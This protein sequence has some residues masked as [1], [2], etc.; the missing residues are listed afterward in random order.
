SFHNLLPQLIKRSSKEMILNLLELLETDKR[1]T[2]YL[3]ALVV[4]ADPEIRL[5]TLQILAKR[6]EDYSQKVESL[7]FDPDP[8]VRQEAIHY[9]LGHAPM[10]Y[11]DQIVKLTDDPNSAVRIAAN[12]A[13]LNAED[14]EIRKAAYEKLKMLPGQTAEVS[15]VEIRLEMANVL[16][17]I[18]YSP[19]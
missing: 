12:A 3:K 18:R 8:R 6:K 7:L 10:G 1:F 5:K 15:P 16:G 11:V 9:V 17:F 13:A 4:H 14:A 19:S 2:H